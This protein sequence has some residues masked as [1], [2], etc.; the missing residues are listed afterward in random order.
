MKCFERLVKSHILSQTQHLLDPMQFAYQASRGVE[1]AIATLLHLVYSH[2]EKPKTH[3]KILFADFSSA[4]NTIKPSILANILTNEFLLEDGLVSWIVDFMSFRTQQV[5][6]GSSYSSKM[7][8]CTG[9]P[10]G[11]VLSPLLFILYTNSCTSTFPNRH[12]IKYADDTALV[13]LL[14]DNEEDHGPVLDYFIN[15]CDKSNLLLNTRKTKEMCIDFRKTT[16]SN[17][18][19]INGELIQTV[20]EYKYL[21]IVLD[22]KLK[23]DIWTERPQ[24]F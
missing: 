17:P 7:S 18:T 21:G 1:D 10:Q 4:F 5:K 20:T 12:F 19:V 16:A 22:H 8:T 24:E 11:C 9:S 23:W 2:L 15:W 3:A 6:V 13:S 14:Y